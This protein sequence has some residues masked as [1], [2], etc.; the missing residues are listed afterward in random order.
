MTS[1]AQVLQ[2][3]TSTQRRGA[4]TFAT[5]LAEPLRERG[6]DVETLALTSANE[7]GLALE[8]LGTSPLALST[9]RALRARARRSDAVI[10][11]GSTTLPACAMSMT[12]LRTPFVYRNIGDP[13]LWATTSVRRWRTAAFLTRARAVV[14]LSPDA[15]RIIRAHYRVRASRVRSIPTGVSVERFQ[16]AAAAVRRRARETLGLPTSG[17]V[18]AMIG[19]L[20]PE[21][22]VEQ[23]IA[24][25]A[26]SPAVMQLVIAGDGPERAR[27]EALAS[28][29]TPGRVTF[30]G[31]LADPR[32]LYA[33]ADVVVLSSLTEGLPAT[34]IEAGLSGLPTVTTDVGFVRDIVIDG[35]T[36]IVV[37]PRDV[38]ALSASLQR[39][40]GLG[41]NTG[42][43]ARSHCATHF[44]LE[45]VADQWSQLLRELVA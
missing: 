32:V 18:A 24:A 12:G 38:A 35:V 27:L 33:A 17:T 25:V 13:L 43:Q 10:A 42:V 16:P 30:L 21:K 1:S 37:P 31:S 7:R 34:L 20:S 28:S 3:V 40:D 2:I 41:P 36:G 11:H 15:E 8:T 39:I 29:Q 23:A 5:D 26:T 4:E 45:Q 6:F 22:A 44:D 9:L 19:A 14:A